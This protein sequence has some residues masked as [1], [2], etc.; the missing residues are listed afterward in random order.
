MGKWRI[1]FSGD[2]LK[3]FRCFLIG[4]WIHI[5]DFLRMIEDLDTFLPA[6]KPTGLLQTNSSSFLLLLP[7]KFKEG[8][9]QA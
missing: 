9:K 7:S 8:P 1:R 5:L 3:H 2:F 6:A 4:F